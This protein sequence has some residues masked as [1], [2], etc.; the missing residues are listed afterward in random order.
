M[1]DGIKTA[2]TEDAEETSLDL[3]R[4][5]EPHDK[6]DALVIGA[7]IVGLAAAL[8][9]RE[10]GREATVVDRGEPGRGAS[11][12]NACT[13]A[14]YMR[15]PIATP[16][17]WRDLPRLLFSPGSPFSIRYRHLVRLSPWL[18]R[19]LLETLPSR[20]R[21]NSESLT[22]LQSAAME[23]YGPLLDATSSR[24][25]LVRNGALY[26]FRHG[27]DFEQARRDASAYK[28]LGVAQEILNAVEVAALEPAI[29]E[30][31]RGAIYY[32]D[33]THVLDPLA[34]VER[35]ARTFR[36][37]GGRI[38]RREVVGLSTGGDGVEV[39]L[40]SGSLHAEQ[41][42]VA[43]GAWSKPLARS[44]GDAVPLETERGYHLEYPLPSPPVSRPC[45]PADLAFYMTPM[46]NRL[47]VAGTVELGSLND[48]PNESRFDFMDKHVRQILGD[49]PAAASRW[50]GFRPSLPDSLPVIGPSPK[51]P[52]ITYAF[53]HGHLGLT[54]AAITGLLVAES[55]VGRAPTLPLH[56]FRV[57]RF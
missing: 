22:A 56:S 45:C 29:A 5:G 43:A 48:G 25:L 42:I 30:Q 31:A 4:E 37:G 46:V 52:R 50:L 55:V 44:V 34:L 35:M 2:G 16:A 38:L 28:R 11:Y 19:F 32:P 33:A 7:G 40:Q 1:F 47:R 8:W 21:A 36:L 15:L 26:Y 10:M 17:M 6:C 51:S 41:V 24:D 14:T 3:S 49:L 23:A 9:L 27:K 13:L 39:Q 54:L 20:T 53:G 12:G 57:D 18:A